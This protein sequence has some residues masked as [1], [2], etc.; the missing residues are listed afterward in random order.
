MSPAAY[1]AELERLLVD[2]AEHT[3]QLRALSEGKP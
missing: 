2:I 3:R 1:T